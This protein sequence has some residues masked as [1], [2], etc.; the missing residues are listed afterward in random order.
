MSAFPEHLRQTNEFDPPAQ[1]QSSVLDK[2]LGSI[3]NATGG[4]VIN[5]G[6]TSS[7]RLDPAS[8]AERTPGPPTAL[9][10]L[11]QALQR[12]IS[13]EVPQDELPSLIKA[14]FSGSRAT[15]VVDSL[16]GSDVQAFIDVMDGVCHHPFD[17]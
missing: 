9:Y 11:D 12:L 3:E 5:H 8:H 15:N 14:V 1:V 2:N 4:N 17:S 16:Q 7:S 6:G 13:C 10:S